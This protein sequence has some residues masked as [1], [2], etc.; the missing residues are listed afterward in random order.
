M[1]DVYRQVRDGWYHA[2]AEEKLQLIAEE[3][4]PRLQSIRGCVGLLKLVNPGKVQ[5]L[6]DYFSDS[7][8]YLDTNSEFVWDVLD[9]LLNQKDRDQPATDHRA[10]ATSEGDTHQ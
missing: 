6:P 8:K 10:P 4:R 5:G 9:A 3:L 1:S 7:I 2:S